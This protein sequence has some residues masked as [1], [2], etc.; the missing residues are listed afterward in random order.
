MVY[1]W[2]N[3]NDGVDMTIHTCSG[4][5]VEGRDYMNDVV[6]P[7][8][9][10]LVYPHPLV[11]GSIISVGGGSSLVTPPSNVRAGPGPQSGGQ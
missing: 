3:T 5:F 8:Y 11:S 1:Q 9:T 2:A 10:P 7:G 6:K 4:L